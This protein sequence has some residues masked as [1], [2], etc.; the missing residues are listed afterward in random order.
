M[1]HFQIAYSENAQVIC[2]FVLC[3]LLSALQQPR[4][5]ATFAHIVLFSI[6]AYEI[7]EKYICHGYCYRRGQRVELKKNNKSK[8]FFS[9]FHCN[10]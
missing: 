5:H 10:T 7:Q 6:V 8:Y 2:L 4:K 1:T 9:G 3:L